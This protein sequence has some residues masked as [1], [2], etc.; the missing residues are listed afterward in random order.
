[1]AEDEQFALP[2]STRARRRPAYAKRCA[3]IAEMRRDAA[4]TVDS[5]LAELRIK[6]DRIYATA[7]AR[8]KDAL[9]AYTRVLDI[10]HRGALFDSLCKEDW[11]EE[12]WRHYYSKWSPTKGRWVG[13]PAVPD[14]DPEVVWSS[15]LRRNP[16]ARRKRPVKRRYRNGH[17]L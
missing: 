10:M 2:S 11:F 3:E 16:L 17:P 12:V 1:M 9:L 14:A 8:L 4:A 13:R 7:E 5:T 6:M 15:F